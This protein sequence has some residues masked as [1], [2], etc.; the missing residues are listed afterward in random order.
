LK[1]V[2]QSDA[3]GFPYYFVVKLD[4][5]HRMEFSHYINSYIISLN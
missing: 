3:I 4:L 1:R 2:V 5:E